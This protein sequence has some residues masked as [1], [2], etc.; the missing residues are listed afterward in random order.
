[1][2]GGVI[3]LKCLKTKIVVCDVT[4]VMGTYPDVSFRNNL[5]L[6]YP[7]WQDERKCHQINK[8]DKFSATQHPSIV[9]CYN[10]NQKTIDG[11]LNRC[12]KLANLKS[13]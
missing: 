5:Y 2:A 8:I 12:Y 11:M 7:K 10:A 13:R 9:K 4:P 1:M 6:P 3:R